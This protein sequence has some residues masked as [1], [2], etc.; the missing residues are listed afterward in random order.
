[1]I[2]QIL[3]T[4]VASFLGTIGF[5]I[6]IRAPRRAW[7]PASLIGMGAYVVY[8]LLDRTGLGEAGAIFVS[9]LLG[10][11]AALLCARK[12]KMIGTVFLILSIVAFVPGLGLY[13]SMEYLGSGQTQT[14][15]E[16]LVSAMISIA[17][18]VLGQGTGNFLWHALL[19]VNPDSAER[20]RSKKPLAQT[21]G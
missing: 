4:A 6:L 13:R 21:G 9:S 14:G 7:V 12:M 5:A 1:M 10:S 3:I 16:Q 20:T 19:K 8:W 18:I 2:E 11:M 15:A 17:M